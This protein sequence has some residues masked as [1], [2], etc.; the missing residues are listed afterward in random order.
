MSISRHGLYW[1]A[2]VQLSGSKI[3]VE[4]Y[5]RFIPR[6]EDFIS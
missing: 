5:R 6:D 4:L 2:L 3:N 1:S